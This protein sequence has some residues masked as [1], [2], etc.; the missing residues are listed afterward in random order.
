MKQD[1]YFNCGPASTQV[2]LNSRGIFVDEG[3][4]ARELGTTTN[5]TDFIGLIERVL[6]ALVPEANYTTVSMP[7]DPPTVEQTNRLWDD[8]RRSVDAGWGVIV[9]IVA[10]PSNYP[11]GANGSSSPAYGGGTVFHYM[12]AMGYEDVGR[13]RFVWIADSGFAPYGYWTTLEQLASLIPPKGYCFANVVPAPQVGPDD[14]VWAD[15]L[16]QLMGP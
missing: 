10:P 2:V 13:G 14:S 7:N 3:T 16:Q 9:N 5:G 6:D 1:T 8:I 4:L 11:R 12:T 15:N